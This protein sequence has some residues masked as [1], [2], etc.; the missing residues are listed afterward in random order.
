MCLL[1]LI[2]TDAN[3]NQHVYL[4]DAAFA[5]I[6]VWI[7]IISNVV[8]PEYIIDGFNIILKN[9]SFPVIGLSGIRWYKYYILTSLVNF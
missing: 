9:I 6:Q 7:I 3:F 5:L 4:I 2:L 1:S 8:F